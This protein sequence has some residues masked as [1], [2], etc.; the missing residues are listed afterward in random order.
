MR[1]LNKNPG[2]KL[3]FKHWNQKVSVQMDHSDLDIEQFH[4]LCKTLAYAAGFGDE[5]VR[6]YFGEN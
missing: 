1:D 4:D 6:E 5:N 2:C 3:S